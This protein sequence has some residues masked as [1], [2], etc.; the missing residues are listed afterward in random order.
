MA[1][2]IHRYTVTV[3]CLFQKEKKKALPDQALLPET[4]LVLHYVSYLTPPSTVQPTNSKRLSLPCTIQ[5]YPVMQA[6]MCSFYT[7][8]S[9]SYGRLQ[10]SSIILDQGR[11]VN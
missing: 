6:L 2:Q 9:I 1:I 3:N 8:L 4:T 10:D 7:V 5:L 11:I